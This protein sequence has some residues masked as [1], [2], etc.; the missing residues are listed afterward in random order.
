[1]RPFAVLAL[2]FALT[3]GPALAAPGL[4][5]VETGDLRGASADGVLSFKAVPYAA[6]PVGKLRWRMPRPPAP[7]DGVRD[8][9]AVGPACLQAPVL[10]ESYPVPGPY[11][12]DCLT[13]NVWAPARPDR[14]LP[15][16]VWIHGGGFTNGGAAAAAFDGAALA[17]Q[18][19]VLV[20]LNYR[21]GR[22][23][24]FAHP[25]LTAEA[26]G[27]A[28]GNY[29]L[30]D[31]IAALQWVRRN[32]AAFGGDPGNVTLMGESSGGLAVAALMTSPAA[33]GLFHKA[34]IQSA[35][36]RQPLP[37][38]TGPSLD[39]GRSMEA[40]GTAFAGH[41]RTAR[42]LRRLSGRR[43]LAGRNMVDNIERRTAVNLMVDG[44]L[45]PGDPL[46]LFEQGRQA[47][48]PLLIGANSDEL[49]PVFGAV[50]G[51]AMGQFGPRAAALRQA[52]RPP[53]G[54]DQTHRFVSDLLAV[55]PA[56]RMATLAARTGQPVFLYR[57]GYV[58]QK[59]RRPGRGAAHASE[60][61]Y[62]FDNPSALRRPTDPDRAMASAVSAAWVR[63]ARTGDPSGPGGWDWPRYD[64]TRPVLVIGETGPRLVHD[65]D[66][67]RL[68]LIESLYPTTIWTWPRQ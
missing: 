44:T 27:E 65:P 53:G 68:D 41:R 48:I 43:V 22:F 67:E 21:L 13:L 58:A 50:S 2:L 23:G 20:S 56:R 15:V 52:W 8:A 47:R 42:Q 62:V 40:I 59:D 49:T 31:Q 24:F 54:P 9:T 60:I 6:P 17:G 30:A 37:A 25:A 19:V 1:M 63:F 51:L 45:L 7:W 38:L 55:E 10:G 5:R 29:G 3:A 34:I 33:E 26:T 64:E 35:G 12:E 4:V 36:G 11:S 61:P 28:R 39:G 18:G 32:I 14:P 46:T 16:I 66:G 57:F